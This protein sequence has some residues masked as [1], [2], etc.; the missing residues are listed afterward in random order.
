MPFF[1]LYPGFLALS[2]KS[3]RSFRLG[4]FFLG[5]FYVEGS[6]VERSPSG[7]SWRWKCT[8][9]LNNLLICAATQ[10]GRELQQPSLEAMGNYNF[11]HFGEIIIC[12]NLFNTTNS[13]IRCYCL[14]V[15]MEFALCSVDCEYIVFLSQSLSNVWISVRN[16]TIVNFFLREKEKKTKQN[17][18]TKNQ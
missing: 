2:M 11:T 6:Q 1:V 9:S 13:H 16:Y 14:V 12:W 18:T 7:P 15:L 10:T 3:D 8:S 5:L 4:L 17:I